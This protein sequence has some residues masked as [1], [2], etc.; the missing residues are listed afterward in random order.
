MPYPH[1]GPTGLGQLAQQ[2]AHVLYQHRL[3][4]TRQ[5]HQLIAPHHA[6]TEYM[7]R[8]LHTLRKAGLAETVGRRQSGQ[9]ELLWWLTEKGA[10]AVES[11]GLLPQRSYR[12]S[13]EAALGP[14]QEHTLATVDTG[15]AF[16]DWARR[17]DHE[18][19]PLDWSPETAHY[20]RDDARPGE[21]LRL[22]PDAVLN[23][24]HTDP[25][26]RQRTLLTF[27]IEVDRTQMTIARL[28]QKLHAYAAYHAYTP[29]QPT[30]RG[31]R[32]GRRTTSMPAWR[33]RYPAFPRLLIVLTGASDARL[34]RR[35]ADLRSLA[36]SDPALTTTALRAG[37]TTLGQL[38]RH[39]PFAPV[40]TPVLGAATPTEAWLRPPAPAGQGAAA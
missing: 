40:F 15:L 14:L 6:R 26:A 11:A 25:R 2:A 16:V 19:G 1:T 39:G 13:P 10:T 38:Q 37:V 4:S 28:A 31:A 36:A 35:I 33:Y 34:A 5:L 27:F 3:V 7:R 29:Q 20:Y 18:C 21:D 8:Q 23:Y 17:L 32:A 9:T 12:M 22:I 24:V 30:G